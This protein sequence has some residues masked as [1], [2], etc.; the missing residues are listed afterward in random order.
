M[1]VESQGS[2]STTRW[3][4]LGAAASDDAAALETLSRVYYPPVYAFL[5]RAGHSP[6]SAEELA[7]GFFTDVVL[8]R[9]LFQRADRASGRLRDLILRAL[10]N[11]RIDA[12]RRAVVR[13]RYRRAPLDVLEREEALVGGSSEHD[14]DATFQRRLALSTLEEALRRCEDYFVGRGMGRHWRV[15][16]ARVLLPAQHC[17]RPTP[18]AELVAEYG[19]RNQA[20][21]SAAVQEVSRR[22]KILLQQVLAETDL[23]SDAGEALRQ[24]LRDLSP[25][26]TSPL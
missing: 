2:F 9:R 14:P 20:C 25:K 23:S 15:Y 12:H 11:Y 16:E 5:R 8:T 26:T 22:A 3:S 13:G 1:S 24:F 4:L 18:L 7:Q 19:F 17:V 10:K 21:V 6:D